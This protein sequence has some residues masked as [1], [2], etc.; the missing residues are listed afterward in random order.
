MKSGRIDKMRLLTI[1]AGFALLFLLRLAAQQFAVS[2]G[3]LYMLCITVAGLWYGRAGGLAAAAVA[4]GVFTAEI[5]LHPGWPGREVAIQ[6]ML[7]RYLA[8]FVTGLL[9]GALSEAGARRARDGDPPQPLLP[10]FELS[11]WTRH[12]VLIAGFLTLVLLRQSIQTFGVSLGYLYLLLI[13]LAG[14]WF[15]VRGGMAAAAA[16]ALIFL[17]EIHLHPEWPAQSQVVRGMFL[18]L[19]AYFAEGLFT[20]YL[21]EVETRLAAEE[22]VKKELETLAYFDELTGCINFRWAM[23]VLEK[24]IAV[25]ARYRRTFSAVMFDIDHFKKINDGYNHMVGN[26][27]LRELVEVVRE[28]LREGDSIGRYGGDEF[29]ILLPETGAEQARAIVERIRAVLVALPPRPDRPAITISAG[30]AAFPTNG[31]DREELLQAADSA[32]Y[33]AKRGGRDRVV[34]ERRRSVRREA[35]PSLVV[36]ILFDG[37]WLESSMLT[38]LDVSRSGL[39]LESPVEIPEGEEL[40]CRVGPNPDLVQER[41]CRVV[42]RAGEAGARYRFGLLLG[43]FAATF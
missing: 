15:G 42:R 23:Q 4:S 13:S 6:G 8:Y 20:G 21:H 37:T 7:I 36:R 11:A 3:F 10:R 25:A 43:G 14:L 27:I 35:P 5:L 29:L 28:N 17:A 40:T 38:V 24:E 2:I 18:R 16:S 22:K 1:V 41:R 34:V 39:L 19:L 32:L 31:A 30:I 33:Q 12:T 26:A 9:M